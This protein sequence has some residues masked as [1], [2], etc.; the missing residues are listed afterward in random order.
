MAIEAQAVKNQSPLLVDT[1][2]LNVQTIWVHLYA[3]ELITDGV[4]DE[5]ALNITNRAKATRLVESVIIRI[6]ISPN[7]SPIFIKI[8]KENDGKEAAKA[9]EKEIIALRAQGIS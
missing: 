4:K 1:I 7:K 6:G 2:S 9:L 5:M 8:L 3:K